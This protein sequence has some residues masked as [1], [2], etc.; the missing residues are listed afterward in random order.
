MKVGK[1]YLLNL[2]NEEKAP[3]KLTE[4]IMKPLEFWKH[5]KMKFFAPHCG[6]M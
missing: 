5:L 4:H 6:E 3:Y 1:Y 2:L